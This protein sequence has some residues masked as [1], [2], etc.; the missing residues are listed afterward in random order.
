MGVMEMRQFYNKIG[1]DLV[2]K[3]DF[4]DDLCGQDL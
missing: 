3:R 4:F 2:E 1:A